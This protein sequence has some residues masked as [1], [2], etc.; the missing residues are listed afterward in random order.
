[1][2]RAGV[3]VTNNCDAIAGLDSQMVDMVADGFVSSLVG[4]NAGFS[5]S[6]STRVRIWT[7]HALAGEF[8]P[9][10]LIFNDI[11]RITSLLSLTNS[12]SGT[13]RKAIWK[14]GSDELC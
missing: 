8:R 1:M 4:L 9:L 3:V 6:I 5:V 11:P 14:H 2:L 12:F 7:C 13:N 10:V